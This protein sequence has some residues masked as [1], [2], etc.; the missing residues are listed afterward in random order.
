MKTLSFELDLLRSRS[1]LMSEHFPLPDSDADYE[2]FVCRK[3]EYATVTEKSPM[4][5]IDFEWVICEDGN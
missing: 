4:Y 2:D 1:Q 3:Y 5:S